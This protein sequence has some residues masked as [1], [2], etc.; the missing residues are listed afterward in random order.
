MQR[1]MNLISKW[2][3]R[4]AIVQFRKKLPKTL[5]R[6]YGKSKKYL[7]AQVKATIDR[8][9]LSGKH[10]LYAIA[11]CCEPEAFDSYCEDQGIEAD[12]DETNTVV[13]GILSKLGSEYNN[14]DLSVPSPVGDIGGGDGGGGE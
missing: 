14:Q 12:F 10:A 1:E 11:L 7:P 5:A 3:R 2:L 13:D 9:R 4:R 8:E 6:D